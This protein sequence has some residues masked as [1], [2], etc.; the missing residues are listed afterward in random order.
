VG[1]SGL[2]AMKKGV[3]LACDPHEN[4]KKLINDTIFI[5]FYNYSFYKISLIGKI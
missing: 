2:P 5:A 4:I 3:C 1:Q